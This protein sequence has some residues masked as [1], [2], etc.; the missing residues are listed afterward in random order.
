MAK[1]YYMQKAETY[2][3]GRDI[4]NHLWYW[5][6]KLDGRYFI[7]DGGIS[8]G[9]E[10][11][12]IPWANDH[13]ISTG[14]WSSHGKIVHYLPEW[15]HGLPNVWLDGELYMG[16]GRFQETM[17]VTKTFTP[18]ARWHNVK[19]MVFGCPRADYFV[20][21]RLVEWGN[22]RTSAGKNFFINSAKWKNGTIG[23]YVG[24][25]FDDC[26][27][28]INSCKNHV[29]WAVVS[30]DVMPIAN[31]I[32]ESGGEGIM[33]R[34]GLDVWMTQRCKTIL[35]L[36]PFKDDEAVVIGHNPGTEKYTGM[37][38]SYNLTWKVPSPFNK[39]GFFSLSGMDDAER[40]NPKPV[41]SRIT[42]KYRE[43]T[44]D[45]VPKEA[46]L[47]RERPSDE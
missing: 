15:E 25:I 17:S 18:D 4:V 30:G 46:R 44:V 24:G 1:Q 5:S 37:L 43:L 22:Q 28:M 26:I 19:A 39:V 36:K 34:W 9:M 41:G 38:G 12:G 42:F 40:L 6:E 47:W 11:G 7:W 33:L 13:G 23:R 27:P 29:S 10:C 31:E 3:P 20:K 8:K 32:A 2:K 14:M 16:R 35:K 45:G 21:D